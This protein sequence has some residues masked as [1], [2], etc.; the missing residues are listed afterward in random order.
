[1]LPSRAADVKRRKKSNSRFV[2]DIGAVILTATPLR[3]MF[4]TVFI[5]SFNKHIS[6]C[7]H[8]IFFLNFCL[9]FTVIVFRSCFTHL[10]NR[11][12]Y[13]IIISANF[14]FETHICLGALRVVYIANLW[15]TTGIRNLTLQLSRIIRVLMIKIFWE[16]NF[17][18]FLLIC[19]ANILL[20]TKNYFPRENYSKSCMHFIC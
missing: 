15:H 7:P 17:K 10:R 5:N 3:T 9:Y 6:P 16:N 20:G 14:S 1:M 8:Y 2:E 12:P 18:E 13:S 11:L 4:L 19:V